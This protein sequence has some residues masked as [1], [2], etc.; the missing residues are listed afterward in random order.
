MG[1]AIAAK[2]RNKRS[3][4]GAIVS[5]KFGNAV[6]RNRIRRIFQEAFRAAGKNLKQNLDIVIIPRHRVVDSSFWNVKEF[7]DMVVRR[8]NE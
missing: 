7:I 5:S 4:L 8:L 3:R 2:S 1:S 6:K